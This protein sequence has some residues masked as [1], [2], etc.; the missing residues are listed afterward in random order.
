[1]T[2]QAK[3]THFSFSQD[4]RYVSGAYLGAIYNLKTGDVF[5][6]DRNGRLIIEQLLKGTEYIKIPAALNN[7]IGIQEIESFLRDLE[8]SSIGFIAASPNSLDYK[9]VF[10]ENTHIRKLWLEITP[11]CNFRC[12]HCYADAAVVF[13]KKDSSLRLQEWKDV[14]S[15]AAKYHPPWIQFIGGEP[16]LC[17]KAFLQELLEHAR[18]GGIDGIEVFTNGYLLDQE[19]VNIL[20]ANKASIAFSIYSKQAKTHD[21][22]TG[23][24]GSHKKLLHHIDMLIRNDIPVRPGF[25]LMEENENEEAETKDWLQRSFGMLV[26]LPDI[27]R[28]TPES[29]CSQG[30]HF[31]R[32]LWQ[33]K[34]RTNAGFSKVTS[35]HFQ[36]HQAGHPC[37]FGSLC[38]HHDGEV[39][40][41]V[42]DRTRKL[43]NVK[44][45]SLAE[46]IASKASVTVWRQSMNLVNSC[47]DCEFRFAC[48]DCRPEAAGID[49]LLSAR[50]D[51]DF[52][53][54]NPCCLYNP[55]TGIWGEPDQL[56]DA[57]TKISFKAGAKDRDPNKRKLRK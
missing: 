43:G 14:I 17:G 24:P 19:W 20:S 5:S 48:C 11:A 34:L 53:V 26:A 9:S 47:R 22:I 42:M 33:R 50:E 35:E 32:T 44:D 46:I 3:K 37:L 39:Y 29:R 23:I 40:P 12:I 31:T 38:I 13:P 52:S 7:S 2:V 51:P 18:S 16:L 6:L 10:P 57:L 4:V 15:D 41:C 8:L 55:Y 21:K 25:I 56:L 49:A 27:I 1:M 45:N 30:V 54:K 28:C 36:H